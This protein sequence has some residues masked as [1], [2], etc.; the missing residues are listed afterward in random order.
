MKEDLV[1]PCGLNCNVCA[2][3]LAVSHDVKS[4]GIRMMYCI[5]C[6]PRNKP[7]AF[8]KKKCDLLRQNRIKYCYECPT[9]PCDSL[10]AIDKRYKAQF[11]MSEIDNLNR[12]RDQG[13]VSFLKAEE[14]KWRCSKCG[15]VVSCH[16]GL[17]F[18]CDL[19]TLKRK[20]R[21]YRW[22]DRPD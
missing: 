15:G 19:T 3:Y 17:C 11:R 16:N 20:K 1:A 10:S 18:D 12:I 14:A 5:G 7:C 8:L 22:D 9:F 2:A 4:K 6:R 21:F 13:I